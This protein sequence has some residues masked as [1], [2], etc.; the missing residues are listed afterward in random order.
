M[1]GNT[2]Q[3]Q[4]Y[5]ILVIAALFRFGFLFFGDVLPVMWDARRY[6]GA[7]I[8]LI[9]YIDSSGDR[10]VISEFQDRK[11]FQH[12]TDKYI[13]GEQIEWLNYQPFSLTEARNEIFIGGPL[14]PFF[15]GIVLY[16]SPLSDF[17][18][19]R[20]INIFLDLFALFLL[21]Q[22]SMRFISKEG[23][24]ISGYI[25]AMYFPFTLLTSHLLLESSTTLL[26]LLT[27]YSFLR[28]YD[29]DLKRFYLLAGIS[30]G[31][32]IL[33][34]PTAMF[35]AAP[36]L[37]A[38]VRYA[39]QKLQLNL[40][41]NRLLYFLVPFLFI[42]ISWTAVASVKYGQFTFRDP[43]YKEA[44]LRQSSNILYEG[45]DL[46]KVEKGFWEYSITDHIL[47]D[48]IGY[49]GLLAKK[50]TRL[51]V[52]PANEF[53]KNFIVSSEVWEILHLLLVTLGLFGLM[54][55]MIQQN[56]TGF[57]I[58]L[59]CGYYI[60]IHL[61]FHSVSRYS[62]NALPFLFIA[63]SYFIIKTYQLSNR[64]RERLKAL[65]YLFLLLFLFFW[66]NTLISRL[67]G[68]V[69]TYEVVIVSVLMRL[70]LAGILLY[71]L[72][73]LL[74][75]D[76]REI[77]RWVLPIVSLMICSVFMF[78]NT[79]ARDQWSEFSCTISEPS[80]K[81]GT[82][83]YIS[84]LQPLKEGELLAVVVDVNSAEGRQ[85]TFTV[86]AGSSNF[87]FVGGQPPLLDLFYPKPTYRFYSKYQPIAIEAFRQYAIVPVD[88]TLVEDEL[89]SKGYL[90]LS[91][92][93]N[94]R[95]NEDNNKIH[96]YG[97]F[98][99]E[100]EVKY[101]PGIRFT[102]IERYVEKG[103]PRIRIGVNYYSDSTISYYIERSSDEIPARCDLS[104][105][106]GIQRG[107][108]NMFLV[109]FFRNGEFR[110]Y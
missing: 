25:Y 85:N 79:I 78:S 87:D 58:F 49:S 51:W 2:F 14:Y 107:R 23:A 92:A 100:R 101:I 99:S 59:I 1:T 46:D 11:N 15:M 71:L 53:H 42:A 88:Q 62:F 29:G 16:F 3:K 40:I 67:A 45:Y 37:L 34:K 47:N 80:V 44:N 32:L 30:C 10:P 90:D 66:D 7:S 109:H 6:V 50:F 91:I 55:L 13:Q 76:H 21:I 77:V 104:P 28:G 41:V 95:I 68:V 102:S 12:Y 8:G 84:G 93:I 105:A 38:F 19:I 27:V 56:R 63:A 86:G 81:A 64:N 97:N 9:S 60:S 33:N 74:L 4:I 17:A 35:L 26:M 69:M 54:L 106:G 5:I 43:S 61:I 22:I 24:I 73:R 20:V 94:N 82:R 108:Y 57:W 98:D 65:L 18:V 96:L 83:L 70:L 103:D 31:L 89:A 48:P 72:S 52:K 39:S 75:A 110:I 36:F